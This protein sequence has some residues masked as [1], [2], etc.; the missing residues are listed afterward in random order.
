MFPRWRSLADDHRRIRRAARWWGNGLLMRT[1]ETWHLYIVTLMQTKKALALLQMGTQQKCFMAWRNLA[2]TNKQRKLEL[3]DKSIKF[4]VTRRKKKAISVLHEFA[5]ERGRIKNSLLRAMN[6]VQG[7]VL[8][9]MWFNWVRFIKEQKDFKR[10]VNMWRMRS[11]KRCYW[12]WVNY[13][14]HKREKRDLKGVGDGIYV[15]IMKRRGMRKMKS[16][17]SD[18]YKLKKKV[19]GEEGGGWGKDRLKPCCAT[20]T[21]V[22]AT[23]SFSRP[24]SHLCRGTPSQRLSC[25]GRNSSPR[26]KN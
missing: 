8:M 12:A 24:P 25:S 20:L 13:V 21:L 4:W 19:R 7:N 22:L 18:E 14:H 6:W 15:E 2:V 3:G 1:F 10:A 16:L 5:V 23:H 11:A 17:V 26:S 9:K